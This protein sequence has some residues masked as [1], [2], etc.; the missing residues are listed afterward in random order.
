MKA[1]TTNSRQSIFDIALKHYGS[2]EAVAWLVADNPTGNYLTVGSLDNVKFNI[3]E[4]V[5]NQT[6]VDFFDDKELV[7]F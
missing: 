2:I 1:V 5:E 4:S 6:V 3:R 7:T